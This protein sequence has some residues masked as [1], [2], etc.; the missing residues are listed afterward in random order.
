M[1]M[2]V[3]INNSS[4]TGLGL[5]GLGARWLTRC[6]G[7]ALPER[8]RVSAYLPIG[9]E[10]VRP[11]SC[12]TSR[13]PWAVEASTIRIEMSEK[14][15]KYDRE[16]GEGA[17]WI[18]E[19]TGKSIARIAW[20]LGVNEGILGNWVHRA[21]AERDDGWDVSGKMIADSVRRQGLVVR[22]IKR[23]N[24]LTRQDK[25]ASKFPDLLKWNFTADRPNAAADEGY[26]PAC[27]E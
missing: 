15:K 19:E 7:E 26:E 24:G 9:N 21:R 14:R 20:A 4:R 1:I 22:R 16:F 6:S 25:T 2:T 13:F 5:D 18:V 10:E 12:D 27:V 11:L 3:N 8:A 23:R 17:V